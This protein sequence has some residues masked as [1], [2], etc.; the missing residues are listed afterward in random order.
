M[1]LKRMHPIVRH[2]LLG[3][4]FCYFAAP[5]CPEIEAYHCIAIFNLPFVSCDGIIN[6]RLDKFISNI[7]RV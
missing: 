5:V 3:K 1:Q 7:F 6:D 4:H 2:I